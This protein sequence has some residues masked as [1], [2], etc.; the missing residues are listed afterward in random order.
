VGARGQEA[1]NKRDERQQTPKQEGWQ[2]RASSCI[3]VWKAWSK[4]ATTTPESTDGGWVDREEALVHRK[5]MTDNPKRGLRSLVTTTV[6]EGGWAGTTTENDRQETQP[7]RLPIHTDLLT[8]TDFPTTITCAHHS[9]RDARKP[10][11]VAMFLG[12]LAAEAV[13]T[14]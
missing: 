12:A 2:S 5:R 1:G 4:S 14:D 7:A 8:A 11:R 3:E 10:W 6:T 13:L 9:E